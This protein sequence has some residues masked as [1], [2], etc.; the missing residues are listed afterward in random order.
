MAH[1][2]F[3]ILM[4]RIPIPNRGSKS[5][6]SWGI[7]KP[8]L[9]IWL[10]LPWPKYLTHFWKFGLHH[11]SSRGEGMKSKLDPLSLLAHPEEMPAICICHESKPLILIMINHL[12][13]IF[14]THLWEVIVMVYII[15]N[16]VN[17]TFF[18]H[19][20]KLAWTGRMYHLPWWVLLL[21]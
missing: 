8:R 5:E 2:C 18:Q 19:I 14:T 13:V 7:C 1:T 4:V 17:S 6:I 10:T 9:I 20:L 3:R 16:W 21:S 12:G 15:Y 11:Q